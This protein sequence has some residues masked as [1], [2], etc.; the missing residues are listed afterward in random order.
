ML[1]DKYT[2]VF[3]S[4]VVAASKRRKPMRRSCRIPDMTPMNPE[5]VSG[6]IFAEVEKYALMM[7][8]QLQF[9]SLLARNHQ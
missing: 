5:E 1:W 6:E 4:S 8:E 2:S 7:E 3:A 9:W